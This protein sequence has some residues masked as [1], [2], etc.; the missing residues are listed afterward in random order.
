M[1]MKNTQR[2]TSGYV[3]IMWF[4]GFT[5]WHVLYLYEKYNNG[6]TIAM[7]DCEMETLPLVYTSMSIRG[8]QCMSTSPIRIMDSDRLYFFDTPQGNPWATIV[9]VSNVP[10][11]IGSINSWYLLIIKDPSTNMFFTYVKGRLVSITVVSQNNPSHGIDSDDV[12]NECAAPHFIY[13][14]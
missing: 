13:L 4:L 8:I 5:T 6:K 10:N 14:W 11:D 2:G 7:S 12:M 3:S 9:P 1:Y